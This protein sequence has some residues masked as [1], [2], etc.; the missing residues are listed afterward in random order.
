MFGLG[1]GELI[2]IVVI[3]VLIFGSKR[4]PE[5]GAGLGK[6][7]SNFKKSYKDAEAIDVSPKEETTSE[8]KK[9]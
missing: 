8:E 7:I 3:V 6:A 5:L 9:S 4:L 1:T 2:V